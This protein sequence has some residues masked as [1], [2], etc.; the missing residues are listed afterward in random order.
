IA[1]SKSSRSRIPDWRFHHARGRLR[2]SEGNIAEAHANFEL[3]LELARNYR[4]TAP[5]SDATRVSMEGM[6]HEVYASFIDTGAALS[7]D[8]E[9][10][11]AA[12]EIRAGSLSTRLRER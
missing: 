7:K 10:F 5:A 8:R 3:A 2:L 9:T 11:E 1:E 6:L 4:L 12:E